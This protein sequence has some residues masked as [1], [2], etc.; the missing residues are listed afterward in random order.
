[1]P[2]NKPDTV[3]RVFTIA[4]PYY[5]TEATDDGRGTRTVLDRTV[6]ETVEVTVDFAGLARKLGERAC[7]NKRG[8]TVDAGGLVMVSRVLRKGGSA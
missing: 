1:M 8:R 4:V 7:K 2:T 3:A 5:R 6:E